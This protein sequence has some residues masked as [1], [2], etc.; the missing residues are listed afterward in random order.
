MTKFKRNMILIILSLC[1]IFSFSLI[2]SATT[3]SPAHYQ[4]NGGFALFNDTD[5]LKG[6][7]AYITYK[8]KPTVL[9]QSMS[10]IWAMITDENSLSLAQVGYALDLNVQH[11]TYYFMGVIDSDGNYREYTTPMILAPE[12]K[13]NHKYTVTTASAGGGKLNVNGF[14]DSTHYW[15]TLIDF[16]PNEAQYQEEIF[17]VDAHFMGNTAYHER[18]SGITALK[19]STWIN[20]TLTWQF[21]TY[22]GLYNSA[23]STS[24][25][26]DVYDNR[27]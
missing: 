25:Y 14:I 2:A 22:G 11:G 23:Y 3:S 21:T 1:I 9:N 7:S 24:H 18:I 5:N 12:L 13:S 10:S 27:N 20:P 26:I 17:N 19:G 8:A 6:A 15:T 4:Y 16:V